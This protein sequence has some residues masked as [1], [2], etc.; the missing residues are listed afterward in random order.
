MRISVE[1]RR[2]NAGHLSDVQIAGFLVALL[3]KGPSIKEMAYIAYSMRNNCVP[4]HV[5]L[6]SDL[7][8]TCGT[9][10]GSTTFNVSTANAILAGGLNAGN[11]NRAVAV[12]PYGVDVI[13]G[14]E[15]PVGRKDTARVLAFVQAVTGQA[16]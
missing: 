14:V 3:S 12:Q 16:G 8:D 2:P 11:V 5:S 15:N 13:S 4:I 1:N 7:T 6:T 9:G 10:D